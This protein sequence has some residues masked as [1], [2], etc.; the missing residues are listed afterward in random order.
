MKNKI[1][2]A[3]A[4]LAIG[5][6]LFHGAVASAL[7]A[8]QVVQGGTGSTTLS[9]LLKGNGT[10]PI[11]SAVAGTDYQA[12]I[13]L[14]TTGTSGAAT[15]NGTVLNIP[16]YSSSGGSGTVSTSSQETSGRV[17]F[18]TS[19][20]STPALLSGG[21]S[22]FLWDNTLKQLAATNFIGTAATVTSA[23]TTNLFSTTASSTNL[24]STTGNI[25]S[26]TLGRLSN[27]TSNGF[28]KTSG[29][30]GTLSIDTTTYLSSAVT[31]LQ[32][33]FGTA[34][35][36]A[37]TIAT[38]SD[39]N[40]LLNVTN[41]SGTFTFTPVWSGTLA[42]SRV[43][44]NLTISGGTINNT[45]IGASTASTA[46]FTNATA[47]NATTTSLFSTTASSTNLF[48]SNLGVATTSPFA[49][50][51]IGSGAIAVSEY[52]PATST[53]VTINWKN[54]NQQL[55]RHG[56]SATTVS[57]SN[58][59]EGQKLVLVVCNPASGTAGTITWPA[60][61]LWAGGTAPTQTTTANKCDVWSFL[62]TNGTSTLKVLGAQNASF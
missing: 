36:G 13:T 12:P 23:T 27:L 20:N 45:T 50:V 41:S 48:T 60:V 34:Q 30:D 46:V 25:G 54:G 43:A 11:R 9:G 35:T 3:L 51:S 53:S 31:S 6:F 28:V 33:S 56:A 10:S 1:L 40:L 8:F 16:Q 14:T 39:T 5:G 58:Y 26:L 38:S 21:D 62:A 32:Q 52:Q 15:F 57:F 24:F 22:G 19:T 61:I 4:G 7:S 37:L 29:G 17:P 55:Y 18:W 44:D 59:I 49:K 2:I 42:D 47:T